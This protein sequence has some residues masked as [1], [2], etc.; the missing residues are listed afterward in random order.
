VS[1]EG[2]FLNELNQAAS[3]ADE[4][5]LIK[6]TRERLAE[7]EAEE[8]AEVELGSRVELAEN[9][10]FRGRWRGDDGTMRTKDGSISVY[11]VWNAADEPQF[12]YKATRLVWEIEEAKPQVGDS[13]A[14]VRGK[15]IPATSSDRNPTQRFAVKVEPC[16]DPLPGKRDDIPF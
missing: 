16:S 12:L 3:P 8:K 13:I 11:L 1:S 5:D 9:E 7:L 4:D 14:I 2:D 15:D 6:E 10:A